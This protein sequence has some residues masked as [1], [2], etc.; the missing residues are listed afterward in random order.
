M[1]DVLIVIAEKD[2]NKLRY[3]VD[4]IERYLIGYR[5]IYVISNVEIPANKTISGI[6]YSTDSKVL[7]FNFGRL[8]GV[9][10]GRKGWY[11]QQFIKLFQELT[12]NDYLVI[13]ADVILNRTIHVIEKDKPCFLFGKNQYHEPYFTFMKNVLGLHKEYS[14]SFIN[15]IMYFKRDMIRGM[16]NS[17][18]CNKYGFFELAINEINRINDASGF[19]EYETYGNFIVTNFPELYGYKYLKTKSF[20]KSRPW[21]NE[22]IEEKRDSFEHQDIDMLCMHSWI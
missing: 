5:D 14:C 15:E 21:T 16:I 9:N 6:V 19:S 20:N 13:D 1:Y 7:D 18:A 8:Q 10:V 17:V 3:L 12:G 11:V 22:E 4:S 2:F